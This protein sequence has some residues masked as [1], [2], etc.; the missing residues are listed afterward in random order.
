MGGG[1]GTQPLIFKPG[2]SVPAAAFGPEGSAWSLGLPGSIPGKLS[3]KNC[4]ANYKA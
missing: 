2:F 4:L 1:S 3:K